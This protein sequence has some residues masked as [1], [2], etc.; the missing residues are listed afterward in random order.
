MHTG[1]GHFLIAALG[2]KTDALAGVQLG[3]A[4]T[5]LP[6]PHEIDTEIARL[7]PAAGVMPFANDALKAWRVVREMRERLDAGTKPDAA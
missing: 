5:D 6:T 1:G 2:Q 3:E 7:T 4:M